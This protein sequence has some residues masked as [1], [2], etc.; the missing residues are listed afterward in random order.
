MRSGKKNVYIAKQLWAGVEGEIDKEELADALITM[1]M[2]D[3]ISCNTQKL[4][5]YIR[6]F[7]KDHSEFL[8]S[9][10][11][12]VAAPE[13]IVAALPGPLNKMIKI[14][15]KVDIRIRN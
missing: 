14:S 1:D 5:G 12:I 13:D 6:E 9:E 4:S 2:A 7:A 3:F 11:E 15:E 8:N 10:G